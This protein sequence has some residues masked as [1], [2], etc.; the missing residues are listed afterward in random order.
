MADLLSRYKINQLQL[1]IEHTFRYR[2]HPVIGKNASPLTAQDIMEL[3]A[4]CLERHIEL[5]PSLSTFG[6]METVLCNKEYHHLSEAIDRGNYG[7]L[8]PGNPKTYVFLKELFEE[9]LPCFS[10]NRFNVCCDEVGFLGEGQS[11]ALAKKM[12]KGQLYLRHIC[13]LRDMAAEH[14]KKIM[15]WGDIVRHYPDLIPKIPKDITILDWTYGGAGGKFRGDRVKDFTATGLASYGCGSTSGYVTIFPR[16]WDSVANLTGWAIGCKKHGAQGMM[17][18]DWGDGGHYN[19]MECAWTGYLLAAECSWKVASDHASYLRRFT[20]LFLGIESKPFVRALEDL[21]EIASIHMGEGVA[22]YQSFWRHVFF[23][24]AGDEL[25]NPEERIF[26]HFTKHGHTS[27][28]MF[29]SAA[30]GKTTVTKLANIKR[31]FQDNF[32]Q[33]GSDP[34][35]VGDYWLFAVDALHHAADKMATLG[36]GGNDT[37]AARRRL[38]RDMSALRNR[39]EKLWMARN[40]RS[41]IR[42]TL[43]YYDKAIRS[44]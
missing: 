41:E 4:Y 34:H 7:S 42:I 36:E 38:K 28:T 6:H 37:L 3:D 29:M 11:K 35:G 40:R 30:L 31:V 13:R 33:K 21:G 24:P 2:R 8:A 44:L 43:K 1:Y 12:G 25:F 23:A 26:N 14:G 15:M 39:F 22:Y 27:E 18:T 10:S 17:C 32:K 9:Y 19:F 20:K 16:V 5:V